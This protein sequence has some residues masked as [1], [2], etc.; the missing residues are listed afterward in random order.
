MVDM[1]KRAQS[2]RDTGAARRAKKRKTDLEE[3]I[4]RLADPRV[5]DDLPMPGPMLPEHW[6]AM[7]MPLGVRG[8]L[9]L[10]VLSRRR[11]RSRCGSI[12]QALDERVLRY[13]QVSS[14]LTRV[15]SRASSRTSANIGIT[16]SIDINARQRRWTTRNTPF[17]RRTGRVH[18]V[19][20]PR[21]ATGNSNWG[22]HGGSIVSAW[23]TWHSLT[24]RQ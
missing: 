6:E 11:Q 3:S 9:T 22:A 1:A 14:S 16:I 18:T 13:V 7:F 19:P 2:A 21:H 23:A 24:T 4:E 15:G 10:Q 5:L 12:R 20:S 17:T 8:V